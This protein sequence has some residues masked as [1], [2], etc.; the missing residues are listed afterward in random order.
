[1]NR[2]GTRYSPE[3][4]PGS[5]VRDASEVELH[6]DPHILLDLLM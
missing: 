2:F 6:I 3:Y 1:M 4:P 5:F